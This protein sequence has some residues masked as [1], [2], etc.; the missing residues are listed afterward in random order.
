[1]GAGGSNNTPLWPGDAGE[2]GLDGGNIN[3]MGCGL[4]ERW[5]TASLSS[6]RGEEDVSVWAE[7]V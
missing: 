7:E 5:H 1:M 3:V 4:P 2:A 6:L